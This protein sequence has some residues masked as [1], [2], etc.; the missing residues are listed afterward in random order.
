MVFPESTFCKTKL[1]LESLR[2]TF[3]RPFHLKAGE[4]AKWKKQLQVTLSLSSIQLTSL[5]K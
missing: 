4:E 5:G 2:L 3:I 1:D